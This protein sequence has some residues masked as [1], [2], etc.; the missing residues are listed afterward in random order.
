MPTYPSGIRI[1]GL[2]SCLP[3]RI[4]GND[5]ISTFVDTNDEW[6]VS[7]TGIRER[8]IVDE[9]VN[10]SDIATT[11]A[12][13]AL[14]D[15]GVSASDIG[16][17]IVASATPDMA[18][19]ATACLVQDRIG[20]ANAGAFDLSAACSGFVYALVTASGLMGEGGYERA[21]V[22]GAETLSRI[23]NWTDRST[24]ILFGD[25]AGAA[26]V[27]RCEKGKGLLAWEL[28]SNGA[29]GIYLSVPPPD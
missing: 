16:L 21:L 15:A 19:P 8:R 2:G 20:A 11:A 9:G 14:A 24:C 5:E 1:M 13:A 7:R 4:L 6:I 23:T 27:E 26:V 29:G 3:P 12:E 28:G 18:F 22:I 17:V 10:T 25:G